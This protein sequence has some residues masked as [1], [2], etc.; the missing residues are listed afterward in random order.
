LTGLVVEVEEGGGVGSA[1]SSGP[2][3]CGFVSC[4]FSTGSGLIGWGS[5]EN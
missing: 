5:V 3:P 2:L 1:T 4:G